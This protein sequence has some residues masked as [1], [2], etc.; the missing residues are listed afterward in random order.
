MDKL[1]NQKIEKL[2]HFG[3]GIIKKDKDIIFVENALPND[4]V[5]LLITKRKKNIMEAQVDKYLKRSKQYQES[6]CKY[7]DTCGGCN[8]INLIYHEQ[9]LYKKQKVQELIDKMLKENIQVTEIISS[10]EQFNYRNKITIHGKDNKLGLYKK[11][12]NDLIEIDECQLVH[13]NINDLLKRIKAYQRNN[14]C[15][16]NDLVIK[17]TTLNESM[18][19]IYGS[20]DY[21]NFRKEFSDVQVIIINNQVITKA[22]YIKEKILNKEFYISNHSFFQVNMHT[23]SLLYQKVIDYIKDKNYEK[24]LDLYCG[25][26]TITLLI[27]DYVK[28]V[29]GIEVVE[30]AINDANKNKELNKK[31]NVEFI[32]GKTEEHINKFKNIELIIVDPPREG[33]DKTTKEHLKRISPKT[34]IYVSCEPSTLMRDLNELKED[35]E[36][37]EISV[38]DMFPNTYHV[39]TVV[40]L[41]KRQTGD[42]I[43]V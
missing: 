11:K 28:K 43:K 18:I 39:E 17:T 7:S 5:D 30:D 35:F 6:I 3:R 29:Y 40:I 20:L 14:K 37:K 26:G 23:T 27:S 32:L 33:L 10:N 38:C 36:I 34:I 16:I 9:L 21:E 8:I 42:Y 24:C 19:S 31:E 1:L 41:S 15:Q 2:D 4:Y 22:K 12:T 13:K 25:T